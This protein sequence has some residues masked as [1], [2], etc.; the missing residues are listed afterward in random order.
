MAQQFAA[1]AVRI[2]DHIDERNLVTLKGNTHPAANAKNDRGQVSPSLPMTDLIL[3]LSRDPA[4]QAAFD[5]FVANQY[6]V[7]SPDFHQ[8]LTPE[9]VGLNFGPSETDVTTVS[10]W[11]TGHGFSV[12]EIT[13][14]RLSIRF[15]GT[16]AQ[17]ESAFHTEIHNLSVKGVAHIANMSDPQ[18]PAALGS[19]VVGV[20]ALHNFF[21]RPLHRMGSQVTLS[22]EAGGWQRIA[23]S[24]VSPSDSNAA[25]RS[26]MTSRTARPQFTIN[27]PATGGTSGTPAYT[28]EDVSPYDFATIYNVLP[29]WNKGI[30]GTGQTIAIA[31]TSDISQNDISTFRTFFGLPTNR[32]ANTPKIVHPNPGLPGGDDPGIC[33]STVSTATC[34]I[35]DLLENSLDVEWSG[36]VA[37]NA[38]IVLVTAASQSTTDDT[39]YD[40]ES[41]IVSNAIAHVVS[42]SYGECELYE[43]TAGNTE[44][45]TLWQDAASE[46]MSV[47]V[48]AGDSGAASCDEG[49]DANGVPYE[50]EYGLTVSGLAST[51]YNTAVGGTDFNW[52]SLTSTS[53]CSPGPYWST[54]NNATTRVSAL[55]YVPEMP[56]NDTCTNPFALALLIEIATNNSVSGVNNAETGCNFLAEDFQANSEDTELVDTVGGGGGVSNCTTSDGSTVASCT[57]GYAK[58]SWQAKVA[59]IPSDGKRDLPDVSFFSSD[60]FISDSAY[61]ICVSENGSQPCTYSTDAEPFASEVGGTSA[62]TPPMA[63]VM[64]LINQKTGAAQGFANPELYKLAAQQTYSSC[65]AETVTAG[66][67]SCY[68]N[69]IDAGPFTAS[70]TN[71]MPCDLGFNGG[72]SPNCTASDSFGGQKDTI[73][74]LTGYNSGTGYD[75]A[76]GLGS[77]NVANVVNAWP[78]TVGSSKATVTVTPSPTSL[79][80][81]ETL[82]VTGTVAGAVVT[83]T[84]VNV[85]PTGTVTLTA[86][87]YTVST[88]LSSGGAYAFTV[89]AN[90]LATGSDTISASYAGDANYGAATGTAPVTVTAAAAL[91]PTLMVTPASSGVNSGASLSVTVTASGT[92]VTP[93][94]TVTLTVA[95]TETVAGLPYSSGA[96]ALAGGTFTFTI[97]AGTLADGTD[98]LNVLYSGDA[99]Y[100]SVSPTP[101]ATVTVGESTF[102]LTATTPAAITPSTTTTTTTSTVTVAAVSG[103]AGSV[104][105]TCSLTSSP[106]GATDAPTCS[107]GG[108]TLAVTFPSTTAQTLTFTVTTTAPSTTTTQLAYPKMG[109]KG[110]GWAGAGGGAVLA[111]LVFLGLPARR[112]SWRSMLGMLVLMAALGSMTACGGGGGGGTTTT[113]TTDPGTSAG[114]YVF[115]VTGV[116]NPTVPPPATPTTFSVT[117]N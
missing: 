12:G 23:N 28:E 30:D 53:A 40:A 95:A 10:N 108:P 47:F 90:S 46:G 60:G 71:A 76:T 18:I 15:S 2:V 79:P 26:L 93:T 58:P 19:V 72:D 83:S 85:A 50:A 65:S 55:G 99:N 24:A 20:K 44:Y 49:G 101:P 67:T 37:K 66:S 14:D 70:G 54:T 97:P 78:A 63:G 92:G 8:W 13:K 84:S 102:T 73:G 77:L 100:I 80:L 59:G 111:F 11:L 51:P 39:L 34:G 29:L 116:G 6:D 114:I 3:V 56:W 96:Q 21:P 68:F 17:V 113:T 35:E 86:G 110:R 27:V 41:Y 104:T 89:P 43:G 1:P 33:T 81:S 62:S 16:A 57:G 105:V 7:A 31:G 74:I 5:K 87:T 82:A 25:A 61:L 98:T 32:A 52:C 106:T 112:R 48:A 103:Y 75:L 88:T 91:T 9:Q 69:D 117:V 38:Q 45:N 107:G 22:R 94:G 42:V 109:G 64:A 36:A 115:T 4:Q